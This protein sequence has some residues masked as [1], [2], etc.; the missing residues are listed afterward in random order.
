MAASSADDPAPSLV[1]IGVPVYNGGSYLAGSL[2]SLTAQTYRNLEIIISD[3]ASTDGSTD[4]C[5]EFAARDPR[6]RYSRL[7]ENIG[8]VANHNRVLELAGGEFF[9]WASSDDIWLSTYVER[10]LAELRA[11]PDVV[12][13]YSIN[14]RIDADG[15]AGEPIPPGPP[16]DGDDVV[17]RFARLMDI[18]RPIEPFYGLVRHGAL[19][20]SA[21]LTRHPGFDRIVL[22]ELGLRGKLR[23]IPAPLYCRRIHQQ[24]SIRAYP[25]LRSRYRWID[26]GRSRMFLWPHV[27]YARQFAAAALRSAPGARTRAACLW[28]VLRWC[29]WHRRE[30]WADLTGTDPA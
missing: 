6:V 2:T 26:P 23:Q 27:E 4:V 24:Q 3:N 15:R 30:L 14:A 10:C 20:R 21:R 13:V 25:G 8:G 17:E 5:R 22:A 18:Y 12:L 19:L 9:M 1:S 29:N 11:H 28:E 7:P 16:L